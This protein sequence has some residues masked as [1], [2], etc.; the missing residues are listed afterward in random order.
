MWL[1]CCL[2]LSLQHGMVI[3]HA[4]ITLVT[5]TKSSLRRS[6]I[7]VGLYQLCIISAMQQHVY[8]I[9]CM[10]VLTLKLVSFCI[11]HEP[12]RI[13]PISSAQGRST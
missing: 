3:R 7:Y 8:I 9:I 4:Y 11:Q 1:L 13:I 2:K 5:E 6:V 10:H 12:A